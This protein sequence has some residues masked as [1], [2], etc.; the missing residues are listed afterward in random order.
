MLIDATQ[1]LFTSNQFEK[2]KTIDK[3]YLTHPEIVRDF[4]SGIENTIEFDEDGRKGY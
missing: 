2:H 1:E 3:V 4:L